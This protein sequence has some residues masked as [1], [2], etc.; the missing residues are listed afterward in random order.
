MIDGYYRWSVWTGGRIFQRSALRETEAT[1]RTAQKA[2]VAAQTNG[3]D[4][5]AVRA[6][7]EQALA[8][9]KIAAGQVEN[10]EQLQRTRSTRCCNGSDEDRT[11]A[12]ALIGG[13]GGK[14]FLRFLNDHLFPYLRG[15]SGS[16]AQEVIR[17]I[18]EKSPSKMVKDGSTLLE[19]ALGVDG[20]D[21]HATENVH[22]LSHLY[23]S[24]LARIGHEGGMSGEMYTPRPIVKFIICWW[25]R[26]L[27][28]RSM[29]RRR[30]Q[31][32]FW[33]KLTSTCWKSR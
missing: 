16:E 8:M 19:A 30:D 5:D 17:Q 2:L 32:A 18:F 27:V 21:F 23:E 31:P 14:F 24:M 29:T 7:L 6:Q 33:L 25:I 4:A 20:I 22:T 28:R 26:K 15:L 13:L 3:G 11:V 9:V 12:E 1:L 10:E